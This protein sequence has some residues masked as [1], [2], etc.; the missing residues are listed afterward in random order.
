MRTLRTVQTSFTAGEIDPRLDARIEVARYYSAAAALTNVLVLPQGGVRRR[1][2][3]RHVANLPAAA[4]SGLRLI[5]F[6]FSVAQTF[7]IAVYAA[8]FSVFRSDGSQVFDATGQPWTATIADQVNWAQSADTL[9]LFHDDLPPHRILRAGSDTNWTSAPLTLN[10]IPQ[11]DY[12]S[13]PEPVISAARGWPECGVF[14]QGRLWLGGLKSR[15]ATLLAS[16]AGEYFNFDLGTGLDNEAM[17]LT[18]DT[19]QLN[20]V[21]QLYSGRGLLVFTSGAEHAITVAPPITPTNVA[22][23]EQSRR[24]IRR[25]ARVDEVDNAILFVQ[26]GGAALRQ[27]VYD[28]IEQAWRA[29]MLSLLAPHLIRGPRDVVIRKSSVQ[30]DADTVL[31]PDADGAGVTALTT[32]RS[33]EVA[34]FSRWTIEGQVLG[35]VALPS[36]QAFLAVLRDDVVRLLAWDDACLLDHSSRFSFA[37]PVTS[38]SV[39][40]LAG[41]AVVALLDGRPEGTVTVAGDGTATLPRAALHVELGVGFEV[42]IRTLPIEPRDPAGALIGRKS[43]IV[44]ATVR[45]HRSGAFELR[46]DVLAARVLGAPPA[47]PLDTEPPALPDWPSAE[48]RLDGLR[49]WHPRNSIEITQPAVRPQPLTVQAL[50][51]IVAPAD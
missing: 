3:L 40:H 17:M 10:N 14:H 24:G 45:V 20:A 18:I 26:R 27:F 13:G 1:P 23:E 34:A 22:I 7:V 36:G 21:H 15:P 6:A 47:P 39:P 41:R 2:G 44:R 46:G 19:D 43:R 11:H 5:P 42:L 4:A 49:G 32:L 9:L 35:A 33:Q 30:D 38:V 48:Y 50:A 16:K 12:G 37:E 8:G 28:E 31:L 51:L 29:D 25:F